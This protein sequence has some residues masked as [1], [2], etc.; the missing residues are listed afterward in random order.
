MSPHPSHDSHPPGTRDSYDQETTV[1]YSAIGGSNVRTKTAVLTAIV[2]LILGTAAV[3]SAAP[4]DARV[5]NGTDWLCH[6]GMKGDPCDLPNDRTD[7]RTGKRYPATNGRQQDKPIDCFYVY[8]TVTDEIGLNAPPHMVPETESI[9]RFQAAPFN[10][11]CR[12]FAP[13]T[14]R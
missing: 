14:A 5:I 10:S 7:K 6:P 13:T 8:P 11:Q 9:A 4:A 12:V 1:S 2:A 3:I